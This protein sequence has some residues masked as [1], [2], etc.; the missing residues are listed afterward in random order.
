VRLKFGDAIIDIASNVFFWYLAAPYF[1]KTAGQ[2]TKNVIYMRTGFHVG[3][4]ISVS[5][6]LIDDAAIALEIDDENF[7]ALVARL[8]TE[9]G[10]VGRDELKTLF[11][12][13]LA[14]DAEKSNRLSKFVDAIH[15]RL[16]DMNQP[17]SDFVKSLVGWLEENDPDGKQVPKGSVASF[18]ERTAKLLGQYQC[19]ARQAKAEELSTRIGNPLE[20][21]ELICDVRPVFDSERKSIEGMVP[22][23]WLKIVAT[24]S[25]GMP[26][27]TE[28]LLSEEDL[29]TI[30]ESLQKAKQKIKELK[31]AVSEDFGKQIPVTVLTRLGKQ[32][33]E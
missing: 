25:N 23:T 8:E 9:S 6:S 16:R 4:E 14:N 7:E 29:N 18:E 12:P 24:Q 22:I 13:Q 19:Y 10:F 26:S 11:L 31:R 27:G 3:M 28:V 30:D 20:Q 15:E 2:M 5:R 1:S 32:T 33:N 17:V 21:F